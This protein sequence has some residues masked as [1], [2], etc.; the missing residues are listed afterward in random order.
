M[1]YAFAVWLTSRS[2]ESRVHFTCSD[3]LGTRCCF[4]LVCLLMIARL[5][6]IAGAREF[7][8]KCPLIIWYSRV[9]NSNFSRAV[10]QIQTF[11]CFS[12]FLFFFFYFLV[13]LCLAL[14]PN[15]GAQL[16][17][18]HCST[19]NGHKG[20]VCTDYQIRP[21]YVQIDIVMFQVPVC[22]AGQSSPLQPEAVQNSLN[23]V[24]S[25]D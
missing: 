13:A 12:S 6:G 23:A 18:L 15:P 19:H 20:H 2:S 9:M 11:P 5:V 17:R 21:L 3:H 25:A 16:C 14:A 4:L 8:I 22:L 24:A 7:T 10:C 1:L